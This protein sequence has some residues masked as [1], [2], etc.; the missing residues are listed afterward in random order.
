[1]QDNQRVWLLQSHTY[2]F[3]D[4][5]MIIKLNCVINDKTDNGN[6]SII[7]IQ[8]TLLQQQC[9]VI[10]QGPV[11]DLNNQEEVQSSSKKN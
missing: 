5:N 1:M 2:I 4:A 7:F 6:N 3:K 10:N 9:A 8:A 11:L